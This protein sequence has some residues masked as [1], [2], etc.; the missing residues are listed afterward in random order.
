MC[1][2]FVGF[3]SVEELKRYFPIDRAPVEATANYNVAPSQPIPAIVRQE[4]VNVL[5]QLH[6]G[7]VP[8]WAKEPSIGAKMINARVETVAAKPSFRKAF[9]KRRCLIPADGFYEWKGPKGDKQPVY[10]RLPEGDPFAFAGLW[11]SWTERGRLETPYLSCTIITRPAQG[12]LQAIHH[13][14]PA[15][16]HPDDYAAWLDTANPETDG[17]SEMLAHRTINDLVFQ[18]V[19]R[20]VNATRNN[21]PEN[22]KPVQLE[23]DF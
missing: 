12:A 19:S 16:L 6:W 10:I 21:G 15:I 8:H 14:M 1:G 4:G 2:R 22:I 17:L 13:R 11:E 3:R 5:Q 23:L 9:K 18:P 7:L 20:R